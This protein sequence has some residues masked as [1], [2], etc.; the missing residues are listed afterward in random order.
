VEPMGKTRAQLPRELIPVVRRQGGWLSLEDLRGHVT[1]SQRRA[2]VKA[3]RWLSV[4]H[5]GVVVLTMARPELHGSLL[6]LAQVGPTARLGGVSALMVDGLSGYLEPVA[7]V[8]VPKSQQKGAA[9]GVQLHETRRW[10][11]SDCT[12]TGIPRSAPAVAAV[13][14]ALWARSFRQATLVLTMSIQQG[15]VTVA[16]VQAQMDRVRRHVWRRALMGILRDV[17]D[18]S[19]SVNELDFIRMCRE[20]GIPEPNRQV[21]R[22]GPSGRYVLDAYFD[23][24]RLVVEIQGAGHLVLDRVITDEVRLLNLASDG[25]TMVPVSSLTLRTHPEPFF[26]ALARLLARRGWTGYYRPTA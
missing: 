17:A 19:E 24:Y 12:A 20:R 7:H 16:D 2:N 15:V 8:W 3:G 22:R 4:P 25:D 21:R 1:E 5:R 10:T 23:S 9:T 13:Q 14:G 26:E 11:A 18:G 6:A